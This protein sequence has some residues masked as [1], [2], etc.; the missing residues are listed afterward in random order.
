[1][2]SLR[3]DALPTVDDALTGLGWPGLDRI[4]IPP[5]RNAFYTDRD[6]VFI[7][8]NTDPLTTEHL[9][10]SHAWHAGI[11]TPEPLSAPVTARHEDG[12]VVHLAPYRYHAPSPVP[13]TV[14]EAAAAITRVWQHRPPH[15][16]SPVEWQ[17]IVAKTRAHI[18]A[19][20][21]PAHRQALSALCT[22]LCATITNLTARHA[23]RPRRTDPLRLVYGHG[24]T[25]YG[26][27]MRTHDGQ[28]M[29]LDWG[30]AALVWPEMDA[31]KYAQALVGVP[32]KEGDPHRPDGNLDGFLAALPPGLDFRLLEACARLRA[33]NTH[34]WLLR[35]QVTDHEP[36]WEHT[37][38]AL[39]R[40]GFAAS[41]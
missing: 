1:M 12:T 13:V 19:L 40:E 33:L 21:D 34:A 11:P 9:A 26:N 17:V 22:D 29:L 27:I 14:A 32:A 39:A 30:G 3:S 16:L 8:E 7:K 5:S 2:P 6:K 28:V 18:A 41:S 38:L 35:W 37:T 23:D 4:S 15:G 36:A 20:D 31:A 10:A 25:H 24:D